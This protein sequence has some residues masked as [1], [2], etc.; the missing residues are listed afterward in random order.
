MITNDIKAAQTAGQ[1]VGRPLTLSDS[2][3]L[4]AL[5]RKVLGANGVTKDGNLTKEDAAALIQKLIGSPVATTPQQTEKLEGLIKQSGISQTTANFLRRTANPDDQPSDSLQLAVTAVNLDVTTP[6]DQA[7]LA[8]FDV[9]GDQT[10]SAGDVSKTIRSELGIDNTKPLTKEQTTSINKW[11]TSLGLSHQA[12]GVIRDLALGR[13]G[14][15]A[16]AIRLAATPSGLS[17][18][19]K[20]LAGLGEKGSKIFAAVDANKD[21]QIRRNEL[22]TDLKA[23]VGLD[24]SG[25]EINSWD[26]IPK[27]QHL[28]VFQYLARKGLGNDS[29]VKDVL[30]DIISNKPG[31]EGL[32]LAPEGQMRGIT[33]TSETESAATVDGLRALDEN[34]SGNVSD[35]DMLA[36]VKKATGWDGANMR[37]GQREI[38]RDWLDQLQI[39]WQLKNAVMDLLNGGT[40][41]MDVIGVGKSPEKSPKTQALIDDLTAKSKECQATLTDN[42]PSRFSEMNSMS[43]S[44]PT[45]KLDGQTYGVGMSGVYSV[46]P[47]ETKEALDLPTLKKFAEAFK[48]DPFAF[49]KN[50]RDSLQKMLPKA[51]QELEIKQ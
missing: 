13:A 27:D 10:V 21:G 16:D 44:G 1:V 8:R 18:P 34:N 33:V 19:V 47:N 25:V 37:A 42:E 50:V 40:A 30:I 22:L 43:R 38:V 6:S 32:A 20:G 2:D 45:M 17:F 24:L 12:T 14:G 48:A 49:E 35:L 11:V 46:G 4:R 31:S 7:T 15:T 23:T 5:D 3:K 29:A 28:Q 41:M 39:P 51:I 9:Q 36:I 26:D